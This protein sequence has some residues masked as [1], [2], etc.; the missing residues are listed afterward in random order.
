MS[1]DLIASFF[2]NALR[3]NFCFILRSGIC[4][5]NGIAKWLPIPIYQKAAHHLSG[6]GNS[7]YCSP[8][9]VFSQ[10][11]GRSHN[12]IPP[13]VRILLYSSS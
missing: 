11:P 2:A 3:K 4:P 10:F 5:Y 9:G 1:K 13:I 7:C 12:C 6:K 8:I